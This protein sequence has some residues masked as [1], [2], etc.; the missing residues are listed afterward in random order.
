MV[1]NK[2]RQL[3]ALER[4]LS[5]ERAALSMLCVNGCAESEV[6]RRLAAVERFLDELEDGEILRDQEDQLVEAVERRRERELL[7]RCRE[8]C[9]R[10]ALETRSKLE[11]AQRIIRDGDRK[12]EAIKERLLDP[13]CCRQHIWR[14][15]V[16]LEHWLSCAAGAV[17]DNGEVPENTDWSIEKETN[18]RL[19]DQLTFDWNG[20]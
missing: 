3:R 8:R 10:Y 17:T 6:W 7:D 14:M 2:L 16:T 5:D 15:L 13:D 1:V 18:T 11:R 4:R 20:R 9:R 19:S 12:I